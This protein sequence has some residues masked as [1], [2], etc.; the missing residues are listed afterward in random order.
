MVNYDKVPVERME[1]DVKRYV[2]YGELHGDFLTNLLENDLMGTFANADL[3]NKRNIDEWT[4]FVY[5]ELPANCWGSQEAVENWS[6][7]K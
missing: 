7:I 1:R 4:T 6:G 2:R 3:E 5:N